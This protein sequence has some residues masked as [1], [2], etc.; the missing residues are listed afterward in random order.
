MLLIKHSIITVY[1]SRDEGEIKN[2]KQMHKRKIIYSLLIILVILAIIL[3]GMISTF[4]QQEIKVVFLNIGQ[5]DAILIEQGSK[6]ILID[7]G[8]NEQ[9]ELEELGKYIPF[10]DRKIEVVIATHPDQDHITGLMGVLKNYQV[11]VVIDNGAQSSSQVYQ[12]YLATV[13]K[14]SCPHLKGRREMKIKLSSADLNLLYP[15]DDLE[16]NPQDTNADSIVAKLIYGKNSFLFTGDFPTEEDEKIFQSGVNLSARILKVAHHGSKY[17][18]STAFL[19]QVQPQEAVI[20][21]GKNN[22]YGHPTVEVLNR[23]KKENI[24]ILRTDQLGD[25][26]YQCDSVNQFCYRD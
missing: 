20:S 8:P 17:A 1:G 22:R 16:N 12:K 10:W 2:K 11:G 14:E 24:K 3:A 18:T 25:I 13:R 9:K 19:E 26:K 7:G 6:Q 5:G 4:S 15:G 23:L 21:V